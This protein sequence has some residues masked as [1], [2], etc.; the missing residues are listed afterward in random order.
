[1]PLVFSINLPVDIE[2]SWF[3][4]YISCGKFQLYLLFA[5][6]CLKQTDCV[7]GRRFRIEML[8]THSLRSYQKGAVFFGTD[9]T[10]DYIR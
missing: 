4:N 8:N 1:M 2:L 6:L 3:W 10:T 9:T 5:L 7:V